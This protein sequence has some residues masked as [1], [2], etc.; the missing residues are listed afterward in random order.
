[1]VNT[2]S[3]PGKSCTWEQLSD[4]PPT[5]V[6]NVGRERYTMTHSHSSWWFWIYKTDD[7]NKTF[8]ACYFKNYVVYFKK[9]HAKHKINRSHALDI[10]RNLLK[11]YVH[12]QS[13]R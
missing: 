9:G 8:L 5:Y 1:M 2:L 7:L 3:L 10:I 6:G 4:D 11:E 12:G 13:S